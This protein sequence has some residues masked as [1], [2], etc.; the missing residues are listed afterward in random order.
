M[1]HHQKSKTDV[2]IQ[3]Q[4][5]VVCEFVTAL[6]MKTKQWND[7]NDIIK[8]S[9]AYNVKKE[10]NQKRQNDDSKTSLGHR[11]I[12]SAERCRRGTRR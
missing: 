4:H 3:A 5:V 9:R 10:T 2:G 1:I 12:T 6:K 7:T 11:D 8:T